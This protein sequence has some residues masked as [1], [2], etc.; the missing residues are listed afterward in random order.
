MDAPY[1]KSCSS[2]GETKPLSDYGKAASCADGTRSY[3]KACHKLRKDAW[4]KNNQ[5]R[6]NEKSRLWAEKNPE[7]RLTIVRA[8]TAKRIASGKSAATRRRWRATNPLIA[9]A[10][11]SLRRKRLK[12]ACPT[13]VDKKELRAVYETAVRVHKTVDHVIPITHPK[14]CG[15]HVPWN[16]QILSYR[17]NYVKGNKLPE[18]IKRPRRYLRG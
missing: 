9:R 12:M 18:D 6:H 13:W 8:D 4:R 10:E 3:C 1:N 5:V 11:V 16:L 15:L 2:C 7:K 17:D 14:V